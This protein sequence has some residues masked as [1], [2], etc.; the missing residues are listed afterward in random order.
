LLIFQHIMSE[1]KQGYKVSNG[2]VGFPINSLGKVEVRFEEAKVDYVIIEKKKENEVHKYP[3]NR[4][5]KYLEMGK[6]S[7]EIKLKEEEL[8]EK[9]EGLS[10]DQ[11]D[12]IMEYV[13]Q[14]INE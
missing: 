4:Y 5:M 13:L 6:K 7:A 12:R 8:L 2:K 11:M 14:V 10:K 9:I 1:S 3:Q